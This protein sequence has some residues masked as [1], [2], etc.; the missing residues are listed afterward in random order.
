[1]TFTIL[2]FELR[3]LLATPLAW[4]MLAATQ[5]VLG[6]AFTLGLGE[7]EEQPEIAHHIGVTAHIAGT[8]YGFAAVW[9]LLA[10]P[11][12]AM[13]L[14]AEEFRN[15]TVR[16]LRGSA[17]HPWQVVL[18]KYLAL[19]ALLAVMLVLAGA[20]TASLT[21][22]THIEWGLLGAATL[23]MFLL[24][25]A[26]GAVALA[27]SGAV[28]QPA[29]AAVT[30]F[31]L[32][33]LLW[34]LY[35][36]G[37]QNIPLAAAF[38]FLSP[39]GHLQ[40]AFRGLL[41]VR[42]LIYFPLLVLAGLGLATLRLTVAGGTARSALRRLARPGA[43]AGGGVVILVLAA[44]A[45]LA[46]LD[47]H[48]WDLS[49]NGRN[50]LSSASIRVL[51][52]LPH[53]LHVIAYAPPDDA[54]RGRIRHLLGR[55]RR[56]KPNLTVAFVNPQAA[57]Q[58][59]RRLGARGR[60]TLAFTYG[61]RTALCSRISE[62]CASDALQRLARGPGQWVVFL[63]GHGE[64]PLD[65]VSEDGIGHF[66]RALKKSGLR[67]RTLNLAAS[68]AIPENTAVLVI[69]SPQV[70]Y[71]AG[72]VHLV[73]QYIHRGGNVLWLAE[74]GPMLGLG[75]VAKALGVRLDPG[76]VL[77]PDY[78]LLG[79]PSP[80][81][82]PVT[83]FGAH[84][85]TRRLSGICVLA[86]ARPVQPL[87]HSGWHATVLLKSLARSWSETGPL[88]G[89]IRF[90]PARGDRP[91]PLPLGVAVT[92]EAHGR[93]Q[94]AIVFGDGDFLS[95]RYLDRGDNLQLGLNAVNWLAGA[96][97]QLDIQPPRLPDHDITL[98]PRAAIGLP[99]GFAVLIPLALL[100][101]GFFRLRRRR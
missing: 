15:G 45:I 28:R 29:T 65:N 48:S 79:M 69:A 54:L 46:V 91:G 66:A 88:K 4:V 24:A 93:Q 43:V 13:R 75:P 71:L 78:R 100:V 51:R 23:A 55:Y 1:M 52:Q 59:L 67:P 96:G 20:M 7:L 49:A 76:V 11:L 73:R 72:E 26:Y 50:S 2:R 18:G 74:P 36:V 90:D 58:I 41:S 82:I 30:A 22:G 81:V 27:C 31:G 70:P 47:T 19:V 6:I 39:A 77:Y 53:A 56:Y 60:W 87:P 80:A 68:P 98:A 37:S 12:L 5:L 9:L 89:E 83:D 86:Y 84:P 25:C 61:G 32:L 44:L 64:R 42:T 34:L 8:I 57:P 85:V 10:V 40:Q 97:A 17:A 92:R 33:L 62:T 63:S 35:W 94:R 21:V 38:R 3:R 14:L 101:T 95:N 16:L 99:L